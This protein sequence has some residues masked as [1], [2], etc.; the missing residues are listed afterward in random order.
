M[1]FFIFL[2]MILV[3]AI[4]Y[5]SYYNQGFLILHL[6]REFSLEVPVV[7]LMLS[8]MAF[9]GLLV[10]GGV[11]L[12]EVRSL[13]V[14]WKTASRQ[15]KAAKIQDAY[16]SALNALLAKRY[17]EAAQLFT[18]LL[19]IDPNHVESLWRLGNI[20]RREKNFAEAIRL[21]RKARSLDERNVEVLLGLAKDLEEAERPEEAIQALQE[22]LKADSAN[23]V[24]L[25]GIRDLNT[26][27]GRWGEAH[28]IQERIIKAPLSQEDL[29]RERAIHLGIKY[30]L[31]RFY[32]EKGMRE[33]A[34]KYFKGAIRVDRNFLPG[35]I[36]LG[37]ASI[38][39]GKIRQ[40]AELWE[41]AYHMTSNIFLLHRL[42]DLY[43]ETGEPE[44]I[45]RIYQDA[46]AKNPQDRILRFYLGK[47]FYRLEMLDDSFET[48]GG[49]DM[50]EGRFPDLYR[51]MGNLYLR[52]GDLKAAVEEY[53]KALNLKKR[54]VVPYYCPACDYHT[55]QWSGRCPRCSR[56]NTFEA[57]PIMVPKPQSSRHAK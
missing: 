24:A 22:V 31:G 51:L 15:K 4:A 39:E 45:I 9:G 55:L 23:L 38:Q 46:V 18:R 5:L 32:L 1:R 29:E 47:L 11:G 42:E 36:G 13:L 33:Q 8:S 52:R 50:G 2:F 27:L 25:S 53:K 44:K 21:H 48:L 40:A 17:A 28:D 56:W 54:V 57:S 26:G 6:G 16:A 19:Q 10:L 14:Q 35:Y 20:R 41:K 7:A 43:V 12:R 30:E 49:I 3:G 37:E 34:R